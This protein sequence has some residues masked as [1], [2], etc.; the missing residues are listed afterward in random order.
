MAS[1]SRSA[2]PL[3]IAI[4][5]CGLA[6][7]A[8]AWQAIHKG[9]SVTVIDRNDPESCS[10]VAAGLVTPITGGRAAASWQW[11]LF[12]PQARLFYQ[13]IEQTTNRSF[14]NEHPALRVFQSIEEQQLFQSRWSVDRTDDG[15][16]SVQ[17]FANGDSSALNMPFSAALMW[18]SARLE[19]S[20]YLDATIEYLRE[21]GSFVEMNLDC[22]R[23]IVLNQKPH[24]VG[25]KRD[26]DAIIFCQGFSSRD[27]RWF[28]DLPLHPARGDILRISSP[29]TFAIDH[30]IHH[31][32]WIVPER[33]GDLLLGATYDRKTLD[34][35]V[36]HREAVI[37]ARET[38][39]SRFRELLAPSLR[40]EK[41]QIID[42]R[43]AVR[44][45]SYD[46]HPLMG[47]H[48]EHSGVFCLNGLGS[49]G[50]LMS[51]LLA[52]TLLDCI[53]NQP[54]PKAW[55]WQRIFTSRS[56]HRS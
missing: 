56:F 12:F 3:S 44:P 20:V 42:H 24:I 45:A 46:R 54:I 41:V 48:R 51:P 2:E 21:Q 39:I 26:F 36:D 22:D 49:K 13:R 5:G 25:L 19:T 52:A 53:D 32:A 50:S 11:D 15:A 23:D 28:R 35:V 14:W 6:G 1:L 17:P 7:S 16:I 34:G 40:D 55:D 33:N 9:W 38:L 10:R 29:P 30:V 8:V 37:D 27:N 43:A 4:I 31:S 18:P 47:K